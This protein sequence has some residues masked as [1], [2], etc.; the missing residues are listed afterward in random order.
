MFFFNDW[1]DS[2]Y[3]DYNEWDYRKKY[4]ITYPTFWMDTLELDLGTVMEGV[5]DFINPFGNAAGTGILPNDFRN[6]D[7]WG[8]NAAP[9]VTG[10]LGEWFNNLTFI[11]KNSYMYLFNSGV[12]DFYVESEVNCAYRDWD[13]QKAE[14]FYDPY[15]YTDLKLLFD[16]DIIAA[17][18][19]HKYDYSLSIARLYQEFTSWGTVQGT[20]YDPEIAE[21]C[22]VYY[23]KRLLYSLPAQKEKKEDYWKSFLEYNSASILIA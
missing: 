12:R 18:N 10:D 22:Y 13:D 15:A 5:F 7:G 23:P 14:R 4:N 1:M 9:S 16:T 6:F 8:S 19:F 11:I 21:T 20:D 17:G 3:P 2:R